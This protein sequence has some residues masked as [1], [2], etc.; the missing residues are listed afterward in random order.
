MA[1][2]FG[3]ALSP[4]EKEAELM[5]MESAITMSKISTMENIVDSQFERA[6]LECDYFAMKEGSSYDDYDRMIIEATVDKNGKEMGIIRSIINAIGSAINKI[7]EWIQKAVGA[8]LSKLK[9]VPD[10]ATG[11]MSGEEDRK[12]KDAVKFLPKALDA[13]T[14]TLGKIEDAAK[15]NKNLTIVGT[16]VAAFAASMGLGVFIDGSKESKEA[17]NAKEVAT[18][19]RSIVD[20]T[21]E[22]LGIQNKAQEVSDHA[23]KVLDLLMAGPNM[24]KDAAQ[25]NMDEAKAKQAAK[26]QAAPAANANNGAGQQAQQAQ[27]VNASAEID[28]VSGA[29]MTESSYGL[30][31]YDGLFMEAEVSSPD[32]TNAINAVNKAIAAKDVKTA[33]EQIAIASKKAVTKG[34]QNTVKTLKRKI[35][36]LDSLA[37]TNGDP[38]AK[39]KL[40]NTTSIPVQNASDGTS[41][42]Y[43]T[44]ST[45][46]TQNPDQAVAG[47]N[48]TEVKPDPKRNTAELTNK[49]QQYKPDQNTSDGKPVG[50]NQQQT[51]TGQNVVN[52][53]KEAVKTATN[54]VKEV[55]NTAK[56]FLK[57]NK[58]KEAEGEVAQLKGFDLTDEDKKELDA[59]QKD[60]AAQKNGTANTD[61]QA[62]T[63]NV[64]LPW[65]SKAIA[66]IKAVL[67]VVA[68]ILPAAGKCMVDSISDILKKVQELV[69][70]DGAPVED[71]TPENNGNANTDQSGQNQNGQPAQNQ[72]PQNAQPTGESVEDLF[73]IG[74]EYK[75]MMEGPEPET[76]QQFD[77]IIQD[78]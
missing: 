60:I 29:V 20:Y 32:Y 19:K 77:Q 9:N 74:E 54:K 13:I 49:E 25:K 63:D 47:Y 4:M 22:W 7:G 59:I 41:T 3:S 28:H 75:E 78:L 18:T 56:N 35:T 52:A 71:T 12:L 65:Y 70:G 8:D 64:E 43:T 45:N 37:G 10:D 68:L 1:T 69:S 17:K 23:N 26:Q 30:N 53:G 72:Q 11:S 44:G 46:G 40:K 34:Q 24:V 16:T 48:A 6:I 76:L 66:W 31:A 67:Q 51:G 42:N 33:K 2:I 50:N 39:E 36:S 58:T 62:N 15:N 55:L 61:T 73:G 38:N 14:T 21:R 57:Q 27:P 5:F